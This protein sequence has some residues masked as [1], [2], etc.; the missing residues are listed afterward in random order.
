MLSI[1]ICI[2]HGSPRKGNTFK[3]TKIF[4]K[5]ML[6]YDNIE[7]VEY[8]L[9]DDMP[10]FCHG[11]FTCFEKGENKCPHSQYIQPIAESFREA[12]GLIITTPVYVLAESAQIKALLDHFGYI[13]MAHRPMEEMFSKVAMVISTT[14]GAGTGKAMKTIT[15]SLTYWGVKRIVKC[16]FSLFAKDWHDIESKKHKKI[17]KKLSKKAKKFYRL[18]NNKDNLHYRIFTRILFL[19][20]SKVIMKYERGHLDRQY[21]EEKEWL[22]GDKNPFIK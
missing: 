13:F 12:D 3:A 18:L 17:E 21:W 10:Y 2:V 7:F 1:K 14:A 15:R 5:E 19:I 9:P 4:K 6:K 20:M 8:F 22:N 11:C 16:G